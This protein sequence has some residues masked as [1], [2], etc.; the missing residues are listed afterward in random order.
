MTGVRRSAGRETKMGTV[1]PWEGAAVRRL[2]MVSSD[3][4]AVRG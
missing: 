3:G 2:V 4:E 1:L